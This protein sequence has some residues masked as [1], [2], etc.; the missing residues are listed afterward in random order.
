MASA[1]G[2][3]KVA[4]NS[5]PFRAVKQVITMIVF[6]VLGLTVFGLAALAVIGS[7]VL[8]IVAGVGLAD[9]GHVRR[10]PIRGCRDPARGPIA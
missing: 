7:I 3:P 10:R 5:P 6:V 9:L 2:G 8:F 1:Q 4:S